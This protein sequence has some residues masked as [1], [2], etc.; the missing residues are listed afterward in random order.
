MNECGEQIGKKR[1]QVPEDLAD[2]VAV[3]AFMR[4][5]IPQE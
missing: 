4:E 1:P 2:I 5:T 3:L